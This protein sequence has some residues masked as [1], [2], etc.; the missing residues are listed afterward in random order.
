MKDEYTVEDFEKAVKNPYFYKLNR[1]IE[2]AIR[3]ES[4]KIFE[5]IGKKNGVS[6]EFIMKRCLDF[7]AK[8]LQAHE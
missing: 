3:H 1:K 8:K 5:D 4:Y 7:Y 6:A 2:V